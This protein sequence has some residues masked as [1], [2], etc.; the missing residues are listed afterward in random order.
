M[1]KVLK[2]SGVRSRMSIVPTGIDSALFRDADGPG[3]R[4][5]HGIDPNRLVLLFVGRVAPEKNVDFLIRMLGKVVVYLPDVA[6]V[7]AGGGQ[8]MENCQELASSLGLK[9]NVLFVGWLDREAELLDCYNAADVFVF[10]SRTETQGLALLEALALGIP[11]VSTSYLGSSDTVQQGHGAVISP[12]DEELF[13]LEVFKLLGDS[14][15][16][17]A[18]SKEARKYTETCLVG[19]MVQRLSRVYN[20]TEISTEPL[21]QSFQRGLWEG[22]ALF[23]IVFYTLLERLQGKLID[24]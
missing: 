5:K 21:Y 13:A 19:P 7:I 22:I 6:L 8:D 9:R 20:V 4:R 11:V 16:M 2:D 1:A 18:L 14:S 24:S 17:I 15:R 12:E 3:F 23:F 10:A